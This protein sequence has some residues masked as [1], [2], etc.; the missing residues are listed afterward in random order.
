MMAKGTYGGIL[1]ATTDLD[2]TFER[3]QAGD[4]DVVQEPT[5]QPWG[6]RDFAVRDPAGNLLRVQQS[7]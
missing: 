3:L 4:A 5:E 2:A 7:R 1:L 6:V